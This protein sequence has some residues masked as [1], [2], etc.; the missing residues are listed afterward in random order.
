[1]NQRYNPDIHRRRSIRLR[2]YDYTRAGAYFVTVVVRDRSLRFGEIID[3]KMELNDEGRIVATYWEWLGIRYP[4]VSLDEYVVMPNH[5]HGIIVLDTIPSQGGSRTAPT[6][7]CRKPLGR[8][9]GAFKTVSTK[10][11]NLSCGSPSRR[12]WQRNYYERVIRDE[13]ELSQAREYIVENPLKWELDRENP[14]AV[15]EGLKP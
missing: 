4:H 5:L 15:V 10:R 9:I 14:E 6:K 1:M 3:G 2:G 7:N 13:N 11:I 12:L 8:L